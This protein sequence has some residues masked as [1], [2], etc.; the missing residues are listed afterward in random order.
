M[1][2]R[3]LPKYLWASVLKS[4]SQEKREKKDRQAVDHSEDSH[5]KREKIW[6]NSDDTKDLCVPTKVQKL[7]DG[8]ETGQGGFSNIKGAV[9]T[10]C[11]AYV[12]I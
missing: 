8:K 7:N 11:I 9:G 5:H 1:V 12:T 2:N 3:Q 10:G 4:I 6:F